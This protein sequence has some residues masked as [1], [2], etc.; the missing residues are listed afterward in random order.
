M[1][2]S[3][4]SVASAQNSLNTPSSQSS[5]LNQL[6]QSSQ[7]AQVYQPNQ[8]YQIGTGEPLRPAR[9]EPYDGAIAAYRAFGWTEGLSV[10]HPSA[11][12]VDDTPAY[13]SVKEIPGGVDYLLAAVPAAACADLIRSA[14]GFARVV[15]VVSGGFSEAGPQ[16]PCRALLGR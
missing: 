11:A 10:I 2:L 8:V 1:L 16:G 3:V 15:H 6:N 7:P 12:S 14:A 4:A 5:Q 13:S 9:T